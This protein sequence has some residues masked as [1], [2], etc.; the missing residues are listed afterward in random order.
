MGRR[1]RKKGVPTPRAGAPRPA[2]RTAPAAPRAPRPERPIL[3]TPD[4]RP[5]APWHP[6]PVTEVAIFVGAV[7]M[8]VGFVQGRDG[9]PVTLVGMA[10]CGLAVLELCAREHFA[11]FRSHALLLAL[12]PVVALEAVLYAFGITGPLLLAIAVPL[13]AG[14]AYALRSRYKEQHNVRPR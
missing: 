12:G 14:L 8:L 9:L 1:S 5:R 4:Q 11:G 13:F 6:I 3:A 7:A 2:P 10:V